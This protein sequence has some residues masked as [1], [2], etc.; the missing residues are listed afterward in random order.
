MEIPNNLPNYK[1]LIQG[2]I[3]IYNPISNLYESTNTKCTYTIDEINKSNN[4]KII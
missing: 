4:F 3:F 1:D 2:F